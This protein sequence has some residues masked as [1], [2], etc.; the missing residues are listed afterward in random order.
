MDGLGCVR[1]PARAGLRTGDA[2]TL[3]IRPEHMQE[4][5]DG[6]PAT[7]VAVEQVGGLSYVRL[8]QHG[9]VLQLAGQTGLCPGDPVHLRLPPERLH[10]FDADGNT[11][12]RG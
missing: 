2:V 11:V 8:L 9:A 12:E 5:P 6:V 4:A 7:V 3:G 1:A 10:L